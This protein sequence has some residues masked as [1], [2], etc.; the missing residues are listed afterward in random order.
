[1]DDQ[2]ISDDRPSFGT[3]RVTREQRLA[4]YGR[5]STFTVRDLLTIGFRHQRLVVLSFLLI[6]SVVFAIVLLRPAQYEAEM[7]ILVKRERVDPLVTAEASAQ[8]ASFSGVTEEELNSE[9]ELLKSRDLL[10]QVVEAT[11]LHERTGTRLSAR[12]SQALWQHPNSGERDRKVAYAVQQ[13]ARG[14]EVQPLRK[15]NVIHVSYASTDP[16]LSAAVLKTLVARY[17]D[18][19][20]AMHR[21]PAALDLYEQEAERYRGQLALVQT[22]LL[23]QNRD[24]GVVSV[25]VARDNVLRLLADFESTEQTTLT[26]I[27]ETSQRIRTLQ[28]QLASTPARATTEIRK[29][30]ARLLE[31]LHSTL[32]TYDLK[33]I[34]LLKAFQPD[35]PPVQQL[36]AQIAKLRASIAE[37]EKSPLIEETTDRNPTYDLVL[38][39]LTKSQSELAG[40]RARAAVTAQNVSVYRQKARRLEE[41]GLDQQ[42]LVRAAAQAEQNYLT[43]ARKREEARTS[44]AID[45]QRILNVVVAEDASVPFAP[46]GPP[47][48][49][50]M[51]L[52]ILCAGLVSVG[53]AGIADYLDQSFRTPQ[54]VEAFLG[55]PVLATFPKNV[56]RAGRTA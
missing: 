41:V 28:E 23:Q 32:V 26:R 19:H 13:V 6:T 39:E 42:V 10:A 52:G 22:R 38:S 24:E 25:Q 29:G 35:Y 15:S 4:P 47:K 33:H 14:L 43:Y 40:L 9:V 18:K 21:T 7:T 55:T 30:S 31:Q 36:E 17:L 44:Q 53:L 56:S 8:R 50:L 54:E 34:E 51:L 46:S 1:M 45:D 2:T 48:W 27:A 11:G 37:A 49:M 12:V 20:L 5:A 16:A 3:R